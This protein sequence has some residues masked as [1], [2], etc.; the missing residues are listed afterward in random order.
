MGEI[1]GSRNQGLEV[2][3]ALLIITPS[4]LL[5]GNLYFVFLQL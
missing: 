4:D 3:A 5:G 2:E 1:I